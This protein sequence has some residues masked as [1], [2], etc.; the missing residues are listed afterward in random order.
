MALLPCVAASLLA[1]RALADTSA[2]APGK[3]PA[4]ATEVRSER[5]PSVEKSDPNYARFEAPEMNNACKEDAQCFRGGCSGEV[6]SAHDGVASTCDDIG[7]APLG[8]CG[9]VHNECVWYLSGISLADA[10]RDQARF[11]EAYR[12]YVHERY[13]EAIDIARTL[14]P[15]TPMPAWRLIGEAS[16]SLHD[17]RGAF[18]A[19]KKCDRADREIVKMVCAKNKIA[20]P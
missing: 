7:N 2:P 9:C 10:K 18:Q 3:P 5:V 11:V 12:A 20:L 14:S 1:L 6:C 16:C 13:Q 17:R 19:W 8:R 15:K 4:A